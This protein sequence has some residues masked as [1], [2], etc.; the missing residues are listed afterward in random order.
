MPSLV[1]ALAL[2]SVLPA[3]CAASTPSLLA[4]SKK[5]LFLS[6]PTFAVVGASDDETKFGTIVFKTML[7]QGLDVVPINPFIPESQGV[8][9]LGSL[10]EL[11]DP[12]R[13][14][15]SVV[16]QPAVTLEILR[17]ASALGIFSV[18]LQPG[19]E[20]DAV[21]EFIANS[22]MG[23]TTYIHSAVPLP[24]AARRSSPICGGVGTPDLISTLV[25]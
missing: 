24:G 25:R 16:T 14:S 17:Q 11:A 2:L 13:T 23:T 10:A 4:E 22:T 7:E 12:A 18:W 9:C 21:L 8:S 5:E 6:A 15:I 19:A 1:S 20:D 3:L